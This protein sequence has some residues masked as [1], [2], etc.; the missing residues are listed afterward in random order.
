MRVL[1]YPAAF[2]LGSLV[3]WKGL[4][5]KKLLE[6]VPP[7]RERP[8]TTSLKDDTKLIEALRE[9]IRALE[10]DLGD[11][12][13]KVTELQAAL[14]SC[15]THSEASSDAGNRDAVHDLIS[16]VQHI[17]A[18]FTDVSVFVADS[19]AGKLW[20][21]PTSSPPPSQRVRAQ[22]QK[23]SDESVAPLAVA[24]KE[25]AVQLWRHVP[26]E[27]KSSLTFA[28][29]K[30]E[31]VTELLQKGID[32][33]LLKHPEY[34]VSLEGRDPVQVI[35]AAVLFLLFLYLTVIEVYGLLKL[36]LLAAKRVGLLLSCCCRGRSQPLGGRAPLETKRSA[37]A[38]GSSPD[39]PPPRSPEETA[40]PA[41]KAQRKNQGK[42]K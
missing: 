33:F 15:S 13:V 7:P 3:T 17:G 39:P 38:T 27:V 14:S 28:R 25:K 1:S 31:V 2:L 24:A 4:E 40:Q 19:V 41:P 12:D 6:P 30:T 32:R 20:Q 22:L 26:K 23:F 8:D 18:L 42:S 10:L 16:S 11:R 37:E 36:S 5:H 9:S 34:T 21:W 35:L 29:K